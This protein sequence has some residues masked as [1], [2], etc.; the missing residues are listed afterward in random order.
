MEYEEAVNRLNE[1]KRALGSGIKGEEY[2]AVLAEY[3]QLKEAIMRAK[4]DTASG[5][6]SQEGVPWWQRRGGP[7]LF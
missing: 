4:G 7:S 3:T 2:K 6:G 1:L 5:S